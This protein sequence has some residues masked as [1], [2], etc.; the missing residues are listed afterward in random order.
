[1]GA[2]V[3]V[4]NG[5][6]AERLGVK[7]NPVDTLLHIECANGEQLPYSGVTEIEIGF[8]SSKTTSG[9]LLV[10]P[11]A[12][13]TSSAPVILGT[14]LLP[15]LRKVTSPTPAPLKMAID[16]VEH[17]DSQIGRQG[18]VA[19][20][21]CATEQRVELS[22]NQRIILPTRARS[23]VRGYLSHVVVEPTPSSSL[24]TDVDISTTVHLYPGNDGD[25]IDFI[26]ENCST[27]TLWN[28]AAIARPLTNLLPPTRTKNQQ[29]PIAQ[30]KWQAEQEEIF[31]TLKSRLCTAPVLMY[32]DTTKPYELHTD[33]S[34]TGLGAV[35]YQKIAGKLH[36]VAYA[37]RCLAKEEIRYPVHK[38][39]FL[40]LKWAICEKFSDYLYGAPKFTV[41]TDNNPLTYVLSSAKLDA[42]G[43][44]WLASLSACDFEIKY[45]P[46]KNN[47]DADALSR[48]Q[49]NVI[50][51]GSVQAVCSI[52][53]APYVLTKGID[54]EDYE[55]IPTLPAIS[56]TEFRQAQNTDPIIVCVDDGSSPEQETQDQRHHGSSPK[57]Y[58]VS[59][60]GQ[61]DPSEENNVRSVL[62]WA[63]TNFLKLDMSKGGI[64]YVL[65]I[66]DHFT[67]FAQA[68]PTRNMS[69]R[70]TAAALLGFIQTFG[71][72]KRLHSDQGANFKSKTIHELCNLLGIRKS[73]ITPYHPMGNGACERLNQTLIR[74][75]GT[76][77]DDKKKN[78]QQHVQGLVFAYNATPHESTGFSPHFLMYGRAPRLTVDGMFPIPAQPK[79]DF[80]RQTHEVL[81]WAKKTAEESSQRAMRHQKR[82][83]DRTVRGATL[84]PRD[85]V[86]VRQVAFDCLHKLADK[87]T[88]E[89]YE[90]I[91]QPDA[92]IPVF[93]VKSR[94]TYY[95]LCLL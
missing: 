27:R 2:T 22:P 54:E 24:P 95:F 65:V 20:L 44:G 90:V 42:T 21:Q 58:H 85:Q 37:S 31:K 12:R 78:W 82:H 40:A 92:T 75:V 70:T 71:V 10:V 41:R 43:H 77:P 9:L 94:G 49:E 5:D 30:W 25:E 72:P 46:S 79:T 28:F 19:L 7:I 18:A 55:G 29:T 14:N 56:L 3:S 68:V 13:C 32:P 91:R 15:A 36:V 62:K 16:C 63:E 35:L 6:L 53:H 52:D 93:E 47:Q 26:L 50:D 23:A 61:I 59:Q 87:W 39:K 8:P 69:A 73:R 4:L 64:Q 76:L 80:V 81:Q 1:M 74:M 48:L 88:S 11:A 89:V 17:R 33:A 86:L 60:L 67:R 83:Y 45:T 38:R 84:T 57:S 66:T 51:I 34:S